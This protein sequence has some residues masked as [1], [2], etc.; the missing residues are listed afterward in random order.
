MNALAKRLLLGKS[1]SDDAELSM[2]ARLKKELGE[3][4]ITGDG[5]VFSLIVRFL[6]RN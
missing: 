2:I 3:D 4:F 5:F 1:A 6:I